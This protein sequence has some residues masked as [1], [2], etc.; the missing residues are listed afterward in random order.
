LVA[1]KWGVAGDGVQNPT[2][3]PGGVLAVGVNSQAVGLCGD[4]FSA[5]SSQG[6]NIPRIGLLVILSGVEPG[7]SR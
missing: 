5:F 7:I 4:I 1:A 2:V 3:Y 6:R